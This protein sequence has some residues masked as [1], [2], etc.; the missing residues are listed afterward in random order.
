MS[1]NPNAAAFPVLFNHTHPSPEAFHGLTK[2]EAFVMAAMQ[3][4]AAR[5]DS[6][7]H[8]VAANAVRLAD[9]TIDEMNPHRPT[10]TEK[11]QLIARA[12]AIVKDLK[13]DTPAPDWS[14]LDHVVE[15]LIGVLN[16]KVKT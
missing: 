4:L 16:E 2:R 15:A 1:T 7:P 12:R 14:D 3:G 10:E 11:R 13:H 6:P 5:T 9:Q 8:M